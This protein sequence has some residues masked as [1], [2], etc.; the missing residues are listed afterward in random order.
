[1][2]NNL[3][4]KTSE[5][6]YY[7]AYKLFLE[8]GYE[9]TNIRD[10][11]KNVGIKA[12]TLYFHYKSKHDLFFLIYDDICKEYMKYI[13]SIEKLN[14]GA[15]IEEKLYKLLLKKVEYYTSDI[16]KQKFI[17]RYNLF[18]PHEILNDIQEKHKLLTKEEN[19]AILDIVGQCDDYLLE[20][21]RFENHL[22]YEMVVS[23]IKIGEKDTAALWSIFWRNT[24]V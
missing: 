1:M 4:I 14:Q 2:V 22:V 10:I 7:V 21:K 23:G 13:S 24:T 8:N 17:L 18:P 16:S 9:A 5:K 11:C 12:S 20:Y 6:I 19:Q 3:E 15:S